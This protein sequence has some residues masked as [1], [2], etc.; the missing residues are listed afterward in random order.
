MNFAELIC[1]LISFYI[2][3]NRRPALFLREGGW[4]MVNVSGA[5]KMVS[6]NGPKKAD[7]SVVEIDKGIMTD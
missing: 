7:E 3:P 2:A 1:K 4:K 6:F 5:W